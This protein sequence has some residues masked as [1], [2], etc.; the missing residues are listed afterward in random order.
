MHVSCKS[1][2]DGEC[3]III[4]L[5]VSLVLCSEAVAQVRIPHVVKYVVATTTHKSPLVFLYLGFGH[6]NPLPL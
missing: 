1:M 4:V 5:V 3:Y 6:G 2:S